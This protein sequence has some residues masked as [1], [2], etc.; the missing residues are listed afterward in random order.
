MF[1]S[2][3]RTTQF[4]GRAADEMFPRITAE[5]YSNDVSMATTLRILLADRIGDGSI[6]ARFMTV[7]RAHEWTNPGRTLNVVFDEG[8]PSN[9]LLVVNVSVYGDDQRKKEFDSLAENFTH[10]YTSFHSLDTI[11]E[12][13][14]RSFA[15]ACF[16]S[17]ELQTA[18]L[19]VDRLDLAKLHYLES[20]CLA[21]LPWFYSKADKVSELEMRLIKSLGMRNSAEYMKVVSEFADKYDFRTMKIKSMLSG[22][23]TRFDRLEL[24][25]IQNEIDAARR[26]IEDLNDRFK[27][28]MQ[29]RDELNIRYFG[30]MH[31]IETNTS[32]DS[33]IMDFFMRNRHLD[34]ISADDNYIKF[35]VSGYLSFW[36]AAEA[37]RTINN[38]R[39]F[40]YTSRGLI[41]DSEMKSLMTA[42]FVERKLKLRFCGVWELQLGRGSSTVEGYSYG[43]EY[44]TYMP[45]PHLDVF[46]CTGDYRRSINDAISR[47]DYI[48]AL[49]E[50][51][52]S[53]GSLAWGD[54]TVMRE[55]TEK[56]RG[57]DASVIELPDGSVV[58][59][60]EAVRWLAADKADEETNE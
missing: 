22:F 17:T 38:A 28:V 30:L 52:A 13:F 50:C 37:K 35:Y 3:I 2:P 49:S 45:N 11:K 34:L 27:A 7:S 1:T 6:H 41:T 23:E 29:Q 40:L 9:S 36:D 44:E 43:P 21:F 24:E 60:K 14:A 18:V 16:V 54:Y 33:E 58:T 4:V 31:K 5:T 51:I 47:N 26:S 19:F 32:E 57:R 46:G 48:S 10:H 55:F 42:I 59:P 56:I 12:F 25:R 8:M 53:V 20:A 15:V 39:S